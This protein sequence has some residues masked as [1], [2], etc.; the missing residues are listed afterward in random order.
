V[1]RSRAQLKV[2]LLTA[3]ESP[4]ARA[5]QLARQILAFGRPIPLEEIVAKIDAVGVEQARAAGRALVAG[6]RPTLA[7]LGPGAGLESAARVVES[8]NRRAA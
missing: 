7:A 4:N 8:L 3:L 1:A 5:E 2:G 6:G